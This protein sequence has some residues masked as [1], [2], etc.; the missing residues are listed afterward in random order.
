MNTLKVRL[1]IAFACLYAAILAGLGFVLG[2]LFPVYMENTVRSNVKEAQ[3][4]LSAY[5]ESENIDITKEQQQ[6]LAKQLPDSFLSNELIT[7]RWHFWLV[8]IIVLFVGFLLLMFTTNRLLKKLSLSVEHVTQ[9]ALELAQGNYRAR[10]FESSDVATTALSKSINVLA[11]NLQDMTLIREIEQERLK[12]LINNMGSALIMIGREGEISI[13]NDGFLKLFN[14]N[15]EDVKKHVFRELGVDENLEEFVDHVFMTET[16]YRKQ[17]EMTIHQQIKH[18][19]VY[20]APVIGA[21]GHWLGVVIVMH[22]ITELK[23]LEQVRKDFVANVSHELR[24]PIT[25]I[26]G[27]SET[28]LDGAYQDEE[29]LLSFLEIMYKESNRLQMLVQDLLELSKIEKEGFKVDVTPTSFNAIVKSAMELTHI[30]IEEKEMDVH[31]EE[32]KEISVLGDPNRLTQI[33]VNL[34]AN[35]VSYSKPNKRIDI[36]VLTHGEYGVV[37][38]VDQGIGI[39]QAEIPRI[40]ERFYRVDR[41]RSRNS[42]GT[43]LGLAIVKHLVEAHDGRIIVKS[44]E[45]MGTTMRIYIPLAK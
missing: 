12:T 23:N 29:T 5:F 39:K 13:V 25:S 11:R 38:I 3:Q 16:P 37:E 19:E 40:F 8:L 22:D 28:L 27:F 21:H 31:L 4:S 32:E 9:T 36:K 42:G 14:K 24:T 6:A 35:A 20:G 26:K 15:H 44:E 45:G 41:A 30:Q 34:L 10:A 17:I 7:T 18:M 43:G 1:L 33:V 2:Q